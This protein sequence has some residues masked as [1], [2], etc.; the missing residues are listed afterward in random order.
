LRPKQRLCNYRVPAR[1]PISRRNHSHTVGEVRAYGGG[2]RTGT[3]ERE[4]EREGG[5]A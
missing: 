3:R 1:F 4:R 2:L 5:R